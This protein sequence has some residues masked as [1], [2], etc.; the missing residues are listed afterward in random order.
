MS[1][2]VEGVT[3]VLVDTLG[4]QDRAASLTA[5]TPLFGSLPELDSLAVVEL[6]AGLEQRFDITI[7]GEDVTG[8]VFATI[9][10]LSELVEE[11]LAGAR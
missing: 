6:A 11:K 10:T 2:T 4:L 5:E 8:E 1:D 7:D 9:G 3:E